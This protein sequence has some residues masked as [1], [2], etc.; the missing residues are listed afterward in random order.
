MESEPKPTSFIDR[1]C[2]KYGRGD[3]IERQVR[4]D[5]LNLQSTKDGEHTCNQVR[6][7]TIKWLESEASLYYQAR[8]REAA[9]FALDTA[10][11]YKKADW[12][13]KVYPKSAR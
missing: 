3:E 12:G 2:E 6:E 13:E 8:Q 10:E 11:K 1:L 9:N 7:A 4:E 5:W